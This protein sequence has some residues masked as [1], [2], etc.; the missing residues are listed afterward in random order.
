MAAWS[1]CPH[2]DPLGS[3]SL[4]SVISYSQLYNQ[5]VQFAY[6]DTKDW[7]P[8]GS[9]SLSSVISYSQLYNQIVQFDTDDPTKVVGDLG[10]LGD[11]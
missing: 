2:W 10:E 1:T 7:D 3:S 9:S 6:A 11:Q 5:I 4:S 8:L